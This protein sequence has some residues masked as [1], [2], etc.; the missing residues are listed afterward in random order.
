[1]PKVPECQDVASV[2]P[3]AEVWNGKGTPVY[4]SAACHQTVVES[5]RVVDISFLCEQLSEGCAF[6]STLFVC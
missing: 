3:T 2:G 4:D 5:R 6:V 1:M